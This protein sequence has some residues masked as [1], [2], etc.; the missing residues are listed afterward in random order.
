MMVT[1]SNIV[2]SV[3]IAMIILLAFFLLSY[4]FWFL[5][6]PKRKIP[7][8]STVVSPANGRI[9]RIIDINNKKTA[10]IHKG[11]IGKVKILVKDTVKRGY[12]IVIVMT[13][14]DVH[15]QRSP[16]D[17]TV[18]KTRYSKGKFINAVKDASS[19]QSLQNEKNEIIVKN[20]MIGKIKV[21]QVAGM[22]ARRISCFVGKNQKIHKGEEI[23]LISLGS[24]VLLVIPKIKLNVKEGQKVIDGETVIAR[25]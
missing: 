14:L 6:K 19:L 2:F 17:G 24:Q 3:L 5:R 12:L 11:I 20:K 7:G 25:F 22:L 8:G 1:I 4:R 13:P 15:Y 9:A 10:D 21:V 23:G 16:V 18:I